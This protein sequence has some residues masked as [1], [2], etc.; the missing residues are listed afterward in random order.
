[1]PTKFDDFT[2]KAHPDYTK[3]SKEVIKNRNYLITIMGKYGF[4][5]YYAEWW[6]FDYQGWEKFELIDIPFENLINT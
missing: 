5:V 6:H 4:K 3:L 2:E 1:M